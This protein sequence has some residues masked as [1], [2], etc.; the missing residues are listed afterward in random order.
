MIEIQE[1]DVLTLQLRDAELAGR[2]YADLER[3]GQPI[4]LADSMIAAIAIQQDLI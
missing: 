3:I 4:G 1:A 2:I